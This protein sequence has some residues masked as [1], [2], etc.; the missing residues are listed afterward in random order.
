MQ[1]S[2]IEIIFISLLVTIIIALIVLI[3]RMNNNFDAL[4]NKTVD[5]ARAAQGLQENFSTDQNR[6]A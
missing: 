6:A 1:F 5:Q 4:E 2:T 3:V